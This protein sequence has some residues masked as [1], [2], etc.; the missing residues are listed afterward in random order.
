MA[1]LIL[2][3]VSYRVQVR[4]LILRTCTLSSF[5]TL[6]SPSHDDGNFFG[7][8]RS[9]ADRWV[10]ETSSESREAKPIDG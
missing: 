7:I 8:R 10:T 5:Q 6:R 3:S 2:F 9:K 4:K 1:S